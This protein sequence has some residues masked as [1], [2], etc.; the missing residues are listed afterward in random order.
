MPGERRGLSPR[1]PLLPLPLP[2]R[3]LGTLVLVTPP[4]LPL[5]ALLFGALFLP[6]P[7][8]C[9][10]LLPRSPPRPNSSSSPISVSRKSTRTTSPSSTRYCREPSSNTA[11]MV[12]SLRVLVPGNERIP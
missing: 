7:P 12:G 10:P 2:F 3:P 9:V 6:F 5:P 11:Y 4:L 8:A 1:R